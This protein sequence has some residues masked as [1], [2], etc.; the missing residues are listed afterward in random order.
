MSLA[1]FFIAFVQN[2]SRSDRYFVSSGRDA[3]RKARVLHRKRLLKLSDLNSKYK[4]L[5]ETG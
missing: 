2:I 4:W 3:Y 1:D 5:D